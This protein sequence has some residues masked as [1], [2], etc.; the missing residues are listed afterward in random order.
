MYSCRGHACALELPLIDGTQ[1]EAMPAVF[2]APRERRFERAGRRK[3][4]FADF[5]TARSDAGSERGHDARG[6]A[7][8]AKNLPERAYGDARRRSAPSG[9]NDRRRS[10]QGFHEHDWQAVRRFHGDQETP[11]SHD[12]P[13]RPRRLREGRAHDAIAVY[14]REEVNGPERRETKRTALARIG[15]RL[16][17]GRAFPEAV[18]QARDLIQGLYSR[19][20]IGRSLHGLIVPSNDRLGSL[21]LLR[22]IGHSLKSGWQ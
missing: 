5:I 12:R 22:R 6:R 14:L 18:D 11:R 9:M 10:T 19:I 2:M 15:A 17:L 8:G 16:G 3:K 13:I 1:V 21:D 4:L 20:E 7:A